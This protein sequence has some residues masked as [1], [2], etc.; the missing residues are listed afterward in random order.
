MLQVNNWTQKKKY[1]GVVMAKGDRKKRTHP[2]VVPV[3]NIYF[4][5]Q[6]MAQHVI[7]K[8]TKDV[9]FFV[10]VNDYRQLLRNALLFL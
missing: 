9:V 4:K 6:T 8:N 10:R 2:K 7:R 1:C 5:K 3:N